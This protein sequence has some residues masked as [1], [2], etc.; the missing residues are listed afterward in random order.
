MAT[1]AVAGAVS[2]LGDQRLPS[3][4][5]PSV[6]ALDHARP[7][8]QAIHQLDSAIA[9]IGAGRPAVRYNTLPRT[10]QH[11]FPPANSALVVILGMGSAPSAVAANR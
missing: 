4:G 1:A 2:P 10:V 3:D 8:P 5:M 11:P 7:C 6:E 9:A